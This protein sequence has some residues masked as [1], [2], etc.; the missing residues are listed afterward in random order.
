MSMEA[1]SSTGKIAEATVS[2][3][4]VDVPDV[5]PEISHAEIK[6]IVA[7]ESFSDAKET[8]KDKQ[9]DLFAPKEKDP[10]E[11]TI[12]S[13]I[14]EVNNKLS[15]TRCEYSYDED[16]RRV[17]IKVFDKESEELIREVPPE[18]SLEL[19]KKFR[20]MVGIIV[21]EKR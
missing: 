12:D 20:E 4:Q 6:P 13:V 7:K 8:D 19:L 15:Q 9:Q 17:A 11:K 18:K 3:P 5:V 21:D 2:K 1:I 16:T 14:S 10:S